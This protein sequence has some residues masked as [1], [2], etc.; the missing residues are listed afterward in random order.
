MFLFQCAFDPQDKY[1]LNTYVGSFL[2]ENFTHHAHNLW[3]VDKFD[4]IIGNPPYQTNNEGETKTHPI[5]QKFV[6]NSFEH[7]VEGGYLTM[8]HPSGWRNIDGKFKDT[9]K[10]MISKKILY[11]EI[12]S[13]EEGVK[14]FGA[15]TRYD[16]YCIKN[17]PNNGYTTKIKCQDGKIEHADLSKMGFIPNGMFAEFERLRAKD[18][19]KMVELLGDSSYHT[20]RP[21]MS[22]E[23]TDEFKYPCAYTIMKNETKFWY[24]NT[25]EKGHFGIPKLIWGNGRIKSV[26]SYID[27]DGEYGLTQFAYAIIDEPQNL[28]KLK[29]VFDSIEFRT[30]MENGSIGDMSINRKIIATFRKDFWKEFLND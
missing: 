23:Q 5:W 1:F 29:N 28:V 20:Q 10:L 13:Q 12:H 14:T 9:Q 17:E 22:K 18:D 30:L 8:V 3:G 26:G 15:E 21:H 27:I 25:N 2:S 6:Q 19:D 11:L 24:S 16:F 4:I 7:L